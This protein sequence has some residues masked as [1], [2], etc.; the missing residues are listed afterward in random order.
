MSVRASSASRMDLYQVEVDGFPFFAEQFE[1]SRE[2][3]TTHAGV[4]NGGMAQGAMVNQTSV[5]G[6]VVFEGQFIHEELNNIFFSN[7][8]PEPVEVE[9]KS[10]FADENH[11]TFMEAMATSIHQTAE[12]G[13]NKVE[14]D[15]VSKDVT[16]LT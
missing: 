1:C 7:K 16:Q 5:T 12:S 8:T 13:S 11:A 3:E 15:I 14:V 6:K 9:V 4:G 2:V 10:L